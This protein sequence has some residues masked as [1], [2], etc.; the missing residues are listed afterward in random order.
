LLPRADLRWEFGN[1]AIVGGYRR[2]ANRLNLD[3]LAF[4]DPNAETAIVTRFLFTPVITAAIIDRVGPGS[5]GNSSFSR[6]DPNLKRP[7]TDEY[8]IGIESQRRG[9]LRVGLT[10]IARREANL[11]GVEDV[12]VP[13]SSYS[14]VGIPD[15]GHD[16]VSTADDQ[17]LTAY[18]RLPASY[19]QNKYVLT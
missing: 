10:G 16:F 13:V 7:Y 14:T 15:P 3:L 12:G 1:K 17:V 11:I 6:I 5:A 2:S 8:V 4:G 18:N 19:G 9:W